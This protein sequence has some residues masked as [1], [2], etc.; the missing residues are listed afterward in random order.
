MWPFLWIRYFNQ[1]NRM[2]KTFSSFRSFD[3]VG[4][5]PKFCVTCGNLA[6]KEALFDVGEAMILEKYCDTCAEKEVK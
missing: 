5:N 6:T 3:D 2:E 4:K 1:N